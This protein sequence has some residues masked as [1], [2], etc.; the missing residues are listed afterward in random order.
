[1]FTSPFVLQQFSSIDTAIESLSKVKN[2]FPEDTQ[3]SSYLAGYLAVYIF[4]VYEECLEHLFA[5]EARKT[6]NEK[7]IRFIEDALDKMIRTPNFEIVKQTLGR[8]AEDMPIKFAGKLSSEVVQAYSS[9]KTN[10]DQ[11]SHGSQHSATFDDVVK[12]HK[13]CIQFFTALEEVINGR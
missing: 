8:F 4:G 5:E 11:I 1:M 7:I 3:L 9:L 13:S 10:R 6:G 2:K 12:F